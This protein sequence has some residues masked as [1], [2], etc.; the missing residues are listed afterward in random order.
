MLFNANAGV[1]I[2]TSSGVVG[3]SGKPTKVYCVH[4]VSGGTAGNVTLKDGT[5]TSGTATDA[6]LGTIN[7]GSTFELPAQ[8]LRFVNG[9]YASFDANVSRCVISFQN[10]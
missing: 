4:V 10:I 6:F 9:C 7:T 8:G 5:T 2:L 3:A 1:Q